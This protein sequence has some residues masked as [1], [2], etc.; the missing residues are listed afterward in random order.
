[1]FAYFPFLASCGSTQ[2]LTFR[3]L[4]AVILDMLLPTKCTSSC[5]WNQTQFFSCT[6]Y[7]WSHD[8]FVL[9]MNVHFE[10]RSSRQTGAMSHKQADPSLTSPRR[11]VPDVL[12]FNK[13]LLPVYIFCL[14]LLF[15]SNESPKRSR[16]WTFFVMIEICHVDQCVI[17]FQHLEMTRLFFS[18]S[19]IQVLPLDMLNYS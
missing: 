9:H 3:I 1:M 4:F 8:T 17:S 11:P 12:Q 16:L 7:R 5:N 14:F 15:P 2:C 10:A 19:C 13:Y 6:W 18:I